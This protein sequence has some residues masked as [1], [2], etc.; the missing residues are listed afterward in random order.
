ML[1]IDWFVTLA[2]VAYAQN[3]NTLFST[4]QLTWKRHGEAK[5]TAISFEPIRISI[6][7]FDLNL[8]LMAE[9]HFYSFNFGFMKTEMKDHL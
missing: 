9:M 1:V 6:I 4:K 3:D 8:F 7:T 5:K 2:P